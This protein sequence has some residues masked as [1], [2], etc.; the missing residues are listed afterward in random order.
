MHLTKSKSG[1]RSDQVKRWRRRSRRGGYLYV[2]VLITSL[3]VAGAIATAVT[4]DTARLSTINAGVDRDAAIRLAESELHRS[5]ALLRSDANWRTRFASGSPSSWTGY[6]SFH[7]VQNAEA[8]FVIS[9]LDGDLADDPFDEF[10]LIAHARFGSAQA[11]VAV[12]IETGFAP[13]ELLNYA[14]TA[15][16][17]LQCQNGAVLVCEDP[18]QVADDC[19]TN[20]FGVVVTP[21]LEYDGYNQLAVRGD[22]A[23]SDVDPIGFDVVDRYSAIGTQISVASLPNVAGAWTI[24]AVALSKDLNPFGSADPDGIYWLD[25]AGQQVN[26]SNLRINATLVIKNASRVLLSGASSMEPPRAGEAIL[27]ADSRIIFESIQPQLDEIALGVNLN[28]PAA[29][30]RQTDANSVIAD[31]FPTEFRGIVYSQSDIEIRSTIDGSPLRITGQLICNDLRVSNDVYVSAYPESL[32]QIP[33]GLSDPQQLRL[34]SGTY[35][36]IDTPAS[37]P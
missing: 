24:E 3:V 29:P 7:V 19:K 37:L 35:R 34:R 2:A 28:P 13:L 16:D 26:L 14:V 17:D 25:A 32:E 21:K 8:R 18:I 10:D 36:R 12:T 30:Y 22:Q 5:T 20:S 33:H 31:Q 23:P 1:Y 9:D 4:L 6:E 15:F 27:V 11:A